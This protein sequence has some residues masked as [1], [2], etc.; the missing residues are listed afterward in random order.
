M[1]FGGISGSAVADVSALGT[2]LIP[3]MVRKGY[4]LD[5]ATALTV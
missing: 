1:F 3:Q 4:D 2:F 5:F